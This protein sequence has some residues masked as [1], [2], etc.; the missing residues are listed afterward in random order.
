[1]YT[2]AQRFSVA[3]QGTISALMAFIGSTHDEPLDD[4]RG[5]ADSCAI[6]DMMID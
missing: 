3:E 4:E 1:M 6:S 5:G 2:R